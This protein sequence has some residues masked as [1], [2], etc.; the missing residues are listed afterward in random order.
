MLCIKQCTIKLNLLQLY[1]G[2][3][4]FLHKWIESPGFLIPESE[5]EC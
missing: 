3:V 5:N 4:Q 1:V 2:L